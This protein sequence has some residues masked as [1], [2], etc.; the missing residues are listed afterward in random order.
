MF[1]IQS[2]TSLYTVGQKTALFLAHPVY[3]LYVCVYKF[4]VCVVRD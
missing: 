1:G 4:G 2:A 3:I